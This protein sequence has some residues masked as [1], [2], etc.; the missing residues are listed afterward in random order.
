MFSLV[1][2]TKDLRK[3]KSSLTE[4]KDEILPNSLYEVSMTLTPKQIKVGKTTE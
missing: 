4:N 2:L 1:N 3:K